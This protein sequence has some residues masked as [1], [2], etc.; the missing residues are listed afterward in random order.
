MPSRPYNSKDVEPVVVQMNREIRTLLTESEAINKRIDNIKKALVGL[1]TLV[2][3]DVL[4]ET[5]GPGKSGITKACR[6]LLMNAEN[7]LLAREVYELLCQQRPGLLAS[8]DSTMISLYAV[9]TRLVKRG[10][11]RILVGE[12]GQRTWQW[13][14]ESC[15]QVEKGS[16]ECGIIQ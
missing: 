9:L 13:I 2:G 1:A 11:I 16:V 14:G 6:H 10:E 15:G 8:H 7:P 4:A 5:L 3:D 12:N